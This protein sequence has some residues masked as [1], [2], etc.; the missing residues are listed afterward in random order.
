MVKREVQVIISLESEEFLGPRAVVLSVDNSVI[1]R[2]FHGQNL[3]S[4]SPR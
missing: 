1:T 3:G 2:F 4:E